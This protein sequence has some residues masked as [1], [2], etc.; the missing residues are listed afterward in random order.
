LVI[1]MP[2]D[3]AKEVPVDFYAGATATLAVIL[4]AKF[5]THT[6][7]TKLWTFFHGLCVFAAWLG[8]LLSMLVLG[9]TLEG[10]EVVLRRIVV[11]TVMAAGTILAADVAWRRRRQIRSLVP[12]ERAGNPKPKNDPGPGLG[13]SPAPDD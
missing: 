7:D 2:T 5:T 10:A 11:V 3:L 1:G 13:Q 6:D 12:E 9:W 8:L 4:F